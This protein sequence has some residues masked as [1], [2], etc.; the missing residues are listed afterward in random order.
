MS[1]RIELIALLAVAVSIGSIDAR[2]AENASGWYLLGTKAS[3]AGFT[4]P[5][6]T[7]FVDVNLYYEGDARG[8]SA[9]GVALRDIS[10]AARNLNI[11]GELVL[12][13]KSKVEG[14]VYYNL[15][16][17]LW[18]APGKVLGGNVGFG[19]VI[20]IGTKE[21]NFDL[22]TLETLKLGPPINRTF[23]RGQ[24]FSE[25]DSSTDF[26][27]PVLNALIGWHEGNWHW[28][29]SALVN[30]PIGPW[31]NSSSSNIS[32]NHWGLDTTA[33]ITWLDPNIGFEIS[34]APG[35]TF[36][37]E[38]PDTDYKTGTEFHVEFAL[39]QHFSPKFAAGIAG[40]HYQQVTGDSGAGAVLGDFEGRVTALGPVVTYNFNLGK[41]PVS[42]QLTWMHDFDV[43]N[44]L[45]G[46]LGL[47]TISLPLSGSSPAPVSLE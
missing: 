15:P 31:S 32:F 27:D 9:V 4:P 37:W 7:Y 2:A 1:A 47:L 34:V 38:N 33:A 40:F 16:S 46:N 28:N 35:F 24:S 18:V 21:V 26:G 41:I 23:Q 14:K 43:E 8:A 10:P 36:N 17:F 6:G 39:L 29:L 22:V 3:M 45:E 30:V 5:P 19:A 13:T 25:D 44:R 12:E 11:A 20:P 42:T